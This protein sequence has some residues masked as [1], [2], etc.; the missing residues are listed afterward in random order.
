MVAL[1]ADHCPPWESADSLLQSFKQL[2]DCAAAAYTTFSHR[3]GKPRIR[4]IVPLMQNVTPAVYEPLSRFLAADLGLELFDSTTH[5]VARIMYWPSACK[6]GPFEYAEVNGDLLDPAHYL[7]DK[8]NW[9]DWQSW[10]RADNEPQGREPLAKA[11][12]P[13][14]KPGAIGAFCRVFSPP[15]AIERFKLPYTHVSGP[16]WS[17]AD[18]TGAPGAIYYESDGYF[19]SWHESDPAQGLQSA[20]DLVR[21]HRFGSHDTGTP[22]DA[23]ITER[24]S[25]R[26]M[27]AF[28]MGLPEIQAELAA[29]EF[30]PLSEEEAE[31]PRLSYESLERQLADA[32]SISAEG[33]KMFIKDIAAVNLS[34]ADLS[35]LAG[36]IREKHDKPKPDKT[37]I[38]S[39]IKRTRRKIIGTSNIDVDVML[40]EKVLREHYAE[41]EHIRRFARQYWSYKRG[42]WYMEDDERVRDRVGKTI[43]RLRSDRKLDINLRNLLEE[44]MT[45]TVAAG[46]WTMFCAHVAGLDDSQ[47]PMGLL[48]RNA[49][50]VMNCTNGELVFE[51]DGSFSMR[52]HSPERMLTHQLAV[53]YKDEVDSSSWDEFCELLFYKSKD[54]SDMKRHLE[55]VAGYA[56]QPWREL[57][58]ICIMRGAPNAGKSTFGRVLNALLGHAVANREISRYNGTDAHDTAGLVGKLLL[59][60]EDMAAGTLLPDGFLRL[61]SE[62]KQITVNP[63]HKGV[64]D[65]ICRALPFIICNSWPSVRDHTGAIERRALVWS[66]PEIPIFMRDDRAKMQLLKAGL[67]GAFKRFVEGFSRLYARSAWAIP[68]ECVD[69]RSEWLGA[70]DS[71]AV[72]ISERL[73]ENKK[74][75]LQR[76]FLYARYVEWYRYTQPGGRAVGRQEFFTRMSRRLGVPVKSAGTFGWRG[77]EMTITT[78]EF[79]QSL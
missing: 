55:E 77:L 49:E 21:I 50:P 8:P 58:T 60:D 59:L 22:A 47:D 23:P 28:V 18:G 7:E 3:D 4:L 15:Q 78:E 56:M 30:A 76:S 39:E 53:A 36:L 14:E 37:A 24:P 46:M 29:D 62:E 10:P 51:R 16:R 75:F 12:D 6:D 19:Y 69:A 5:Q 25:Q 26:E 67:P 40:I 20:W 54:P 72:W 1:D 65:F 48:T 70:A 9:R 11:A 42:V 32:E 71:V 64:F 43:I 31:N 66:L 61:V 27:I 44:R 74:A 79:E 73:I 45:S 52:P 63:K 17:Y 68:Q 57:A 13:T 35:V 2:T 41:G 33:R 38:L 34:N